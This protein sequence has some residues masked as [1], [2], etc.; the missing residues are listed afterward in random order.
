MTQAAPDAPDESNPQDAR[1]IALAAAQQQAEELF[2]EVVARGVIRPGVS[3][4]EAS[5]EIRRLAAEL[6]GVERFWHKRI[7]RA[8]ANTVEPYRSNPPDRAIEADDIVFIDFGPVF[9]DWEADYGRTYV[10]GDDPRKVAL[11]DALAVIWE[12]GREHF[13]SRPGITGAELF[14]YVSDC[15]RRAGFSPADTHVGHLVGEFPHERISGD[16][17]DCYI[18]PGSDLPMRRTDP[19]GNACHWIL[20]VHLVDA[21]GEFGGF[22]EQLLDC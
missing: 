19:Q 3:E 4:R 16:G 20:E 5:D 18:T 7:V 6:F 10:L 21:S 12:Q 2:A 8:G 11:R 15:M 17:L 13:A 9:A 1:A 14:A 22:M